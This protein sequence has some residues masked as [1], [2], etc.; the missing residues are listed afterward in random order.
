MRHADWTGAS[1]PTRPV[2]IWRSSGCDRCP[3]APGNHKGPPRT[4]TTWPGSRSD[5][6]M[7]ARGLGL[8]AND[9]LAVQSPSWPVGG[10]SLLETNRNLSPTAPMPRSVR[11]NSANAGS[12]PKGSRS[13]RSA[14]HPS[15]RRPPD[16]R[17]Q[18][19]RRSADTSASTKADARPP[20]RLAA[21]C[22]HRSSEVTS[23]SGIFRQST[24]SP[25]A[26]RRPP[27]NRMHQAHR[28]AFCRPEGFHQ[29]GTAS[30]GGGPQ[31]TKNSS[32]IPAERDG[33]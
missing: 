13:H 30:A 17:H 24:Q 10:P 3:P 11:A 12:H 33:G 32:F 22:A 27:P 19:G 1:A 8:A 4:R 14:G 25:N 2:P 29:A 9:T 28:A 26:E 15:C 21:R 6:R 7:A 16:C 31:R 23:G 5:R 18:G 20:I